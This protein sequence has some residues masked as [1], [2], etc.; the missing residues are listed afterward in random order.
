VFDVVFEASGNPAALRQAIGLLRPRGVLVLIGLGPESPLPLVSLVTK[1]VDVRGTFRF[2]Q[3]FATAVAALAGGRIDPMPL[4][5]QTMP[6]ADAVE[7]FELAADRTR[8]L[9]VQ[10]SFA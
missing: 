5:T 2:D 4:L 10:L 8:A 3:E 7:A 9:K 6:I 1:E